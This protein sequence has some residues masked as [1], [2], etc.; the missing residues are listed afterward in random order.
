[1]V[2]PEKQ[3]QQ[4]IYIEIVCKELASRIIG[5]SLKSKGQTTKEVWLD[6]SG[7]DCYPQ[8]EFLYQGRLIFTFKVVRLIGSGPLNLS[9][10][11]SLT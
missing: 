11:T 7:G 4:E 3:N 6:L 8:I 1:M 10:T 5:A 2:Q 9:R